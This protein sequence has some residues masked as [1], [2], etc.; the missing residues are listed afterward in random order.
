MI[1]SLLTIATPTTPKLDRSTITDK[2]KLYI[3]LYAPIVAT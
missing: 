3:L 1:V 2:G